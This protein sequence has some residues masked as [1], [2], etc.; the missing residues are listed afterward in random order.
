MY[1]RQVFIIPFIIMFAIFMVYPI[2]D[3]FY[4]TFF[5]IDG[6]ETSFVGLNNYKRLFTDSLVW[7]SLGNTFLY[8]CLL[9]TSCLR[10]RKGYACYSQRRSSQSP[11]P[12]HLIDKTRL[13][14]RHDGGQTQP[15]GRYYHSFLSGT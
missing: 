8:T 9:Y 3:S 10:V 11:L 1:K 15:A 4:M 12:Y 2:F 7:K 5:K 14:R 6:F 13:T